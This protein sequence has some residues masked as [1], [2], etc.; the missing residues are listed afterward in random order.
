MAIVKINEALCIISGIDELKINNKEIPIKVFYGLNKNHNKL[1]KET[2]AY[3][4]SRKV[5]LERYSAKDK[6]GVPKSGDRPGT[7]TIEEKHQ[8]QFSEDMEALL[9]ET[10]DVDF[11][12][13]NLEDMDG[14]SF[15]QP[16]DESGNILPSFANFVMDHLVVNG[17]AESSD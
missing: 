6:N 2:E 14:I 5:L 16:R 7:I 17:A 12:L 8:D 10:V 9:S 11:H 4:E 13:I 3:Q 1:V 15:T